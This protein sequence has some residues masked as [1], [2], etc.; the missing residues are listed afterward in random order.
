MEIQTLKSTIDDLE[1]EI[2]ST[3]AVTIEI[4][5]IPNEIELTEK[6]Q[7]KEI[8][9]IKVELDKVTN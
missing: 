7:E 3:A 1:K 9:K 2:Q 4:L 5:V 8:K 6:E